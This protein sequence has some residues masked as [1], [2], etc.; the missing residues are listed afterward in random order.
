METTKDTKSTKREQNEEE[1]SPYTRP[2]GCGG[3]MGRIGTGA[4]RACEQST[5]SPRHPRSGKRPTTKSPCSPFSIAASTVGAR[6]RIRL[7]NI[8]IN[9]SFLV[10][11]ASQMG[12][13]N[14]ACFVQ[15]LVE[16]QDAKCREILQVGLSPRRRGEEPRI[17]RMP[18]MEAECGGMRDEAAGGKPRIKRIERIEA[19]TPR[20]NR[21]L[22]SFRLAQSA[23]RGGFLGTW[24]G[25]R[26]RRR[27]SP[28]T[29]LDNLRTNP[30][31]SRIDAILP[32]GP[33]V[34]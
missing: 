18:R 12:R 29:R 16:F 23:R 28:L 10:D 6:P 27:C 14:Q 9:M 30:Q 33:R 11:R 31:E 1:F 13:N 17:T 19:A 7:E 25:D 24:I 2:P 20:A 21:H 22:T 32:V 5:R 34:E 15:N 26:T 4:H 8:P 3:S